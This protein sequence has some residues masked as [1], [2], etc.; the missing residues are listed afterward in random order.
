MQEG[1]ILTLEREGMPK[2]RDPYERGNLHCKIKVKFPESGFLTS[3][4]LKLLESILPPRAPLPMVGH[5]VEEKYLVTFNEE[6]FQ[7]DQRRHQGKI[8][9]RM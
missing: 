1:D 9:S 4:K 3:E 2:Y 6:R 7:R 8:T 5:D